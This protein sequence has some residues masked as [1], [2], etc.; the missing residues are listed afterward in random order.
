MPIRWVLLRD[1]AGQF[2]TPALLSTDPGLDAQQ[3]VE[4]FVL[5]WQVAVPFQQARAHLGIETQ[6]QWSDLALLRTTPALFGRYSVVT[7]L[8]Q[9]AYP[10][11][12]AAWYAKELPTF[13]DTLALVRRELCQHGAGLFATSAPTTDCVT[14]PRQVLEQLTDALAWAS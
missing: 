5:R 1:S 4:W 9:Q 14:I 13:T 3:V 7:P 11:R 12:R 2:E 6:R 10:V 8:T